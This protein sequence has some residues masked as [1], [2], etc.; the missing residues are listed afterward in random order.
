MIA[1]LNFSELW[2]Q[3]VLQMDTNVSEE[4]AV[5]ILMVKLQFKR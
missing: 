1:K 2:H 3:E 5:S 4:H